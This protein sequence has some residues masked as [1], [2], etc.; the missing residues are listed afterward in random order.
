MRARQIAPAQQPAH[1]LARIV[2]HPLEPSLERGIEHFARDVLGCDFEHRIDARLYRPLA[3]QVGAK[4]MN[5]SDPRFFQLLERQ[6][7]TRSAFAQRL[8][9]LARAF[10]FGAQPQLQ[11]A[12]RFLGERHRDDPRQL[13][14]PR[15]DHRYDSIHQRG[16]LAGARCRLDHERDVEI[17]AN[18]I[19]HRLVG[20]G[21]WIHERHGIARSFFSDLS[22][23]SGLI[24]E[25]RSSYGPHTRL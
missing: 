7:E 24:L 12:R 6:V 17:V 5:R 19:A 9:E 14:A 21:C 2:Q 3:Q 13:A 25:R 1:P 15:P 23:A 20:N 18:P 22:R 4:R 16:G 10:D 11:L 8:C